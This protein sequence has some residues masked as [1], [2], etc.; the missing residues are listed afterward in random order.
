MGRKVQ[1]G[2]GVLGLAAAIGA[3]IYVYQRFVG[4]SPLRFTYLTGSISDVGYEE[5]ASKPGWSKT[6]LQVAPGVR[7]NG[8][9]RRPEAADATWILFYPG[10]DDHMLARGQRL[11]G[12]LAQGR[13][14]GLAV[15][16]YRGFDS[17]GGTPVIES[18][19]ADASAILEHVAGLPGVKRERLHVVGFSIGGHLAVRAAAAAN[20]EQ[21]PPASLS[22]MACVNDIVMLQRA[23]W[24]K[25]LLGDILRTQP[26]LTL[27]PA[28]VLV[29]QGTADEAL[30]GA[31]Q[32]QAISRT[33]GAR[34]QYLELQGVG[35]EALL[36]DEP[37]LQAVREFIGQHERR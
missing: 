5:L 14:L 20:R 8:L 33:L 19:G 37:A 30:Q 9:L 21:R 1:L 4:R 10:N 24:Q 22:L 28:P 34:A 3:A 35:H 26:F 11:L 17:S 2:L 6:Q 16:A 31:V 29:V 7:L 32:G 13:D 25:L 23:P 27:V 18:L 12:K 15:F 36:D